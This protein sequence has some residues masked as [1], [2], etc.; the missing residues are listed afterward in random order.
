MLIKSELGFWRN[1]DFPG[2]F[3]YF[4]GKIMDCGN[5]RAFACLENCKRSVVTLLS[6]NNRLAEAEPLM[7]RALMIDEASF[8]ADHPDVASD[9]NNLALLLQDTRRLD[10]AEPLMRRAAE[11]FA[12]NLEQDLPNTCTVVVNYATLLSEMGRSEEEIKAAINEL[13]ST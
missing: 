4:R 6:T 13:M 2:Q 5:E 9:L 12:A 1:Q 3:L 7:R 11:I 10:A 8:G